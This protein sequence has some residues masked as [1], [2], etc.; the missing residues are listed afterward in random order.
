M[1]KHKAA[2]KA[3]QHTRPE[4]KR[5]GVKAQTGEVVNAGAVIVRQSGTRFKTGKG[6]KL[7]RDHTIYAMV[8]GTVKFGTKEGK[9]FVSVLS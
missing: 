3:R 4:G 7:G 1:S 9:K 8:P 2:G 6:V 5:R